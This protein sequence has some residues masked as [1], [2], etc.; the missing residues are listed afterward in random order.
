M[1]VELKDPKK[2]K[3]SQDLPLENKH[4]LTKSRDIDTIP[5]Q[6]NSKPYFIKDQPNQSMTSTWKTRVRNIKEALIN[7][8]LF[9]AAFSSV[10]ITLGIVGVLFFESISFF[11][12]VSIWTFLTDKQWT[13][14]FEDAHYGI[15]P[16]L[17]GTLVVAGVALL[18]ALPVGT[19]AA[20]YLSEYAP[21]KVREFVKPFLELLSAVPTV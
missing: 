16:L 9:M 6:L 15:L 2:T 3:I 21:H 1:S 7:F 17:S 18:F 8:V 20:V 12:E 13:P 5:T 10:A 4:G 19:I 14:L 11:K